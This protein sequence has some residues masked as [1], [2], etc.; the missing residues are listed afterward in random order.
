MKKF[1]SNSGSDST[2]NNNLQAGLS[3]N[4][5]DWILHPYDLNN[6]CIT[7][8]NPINSGQHGRIFPGKVLNSSSTTNALVFKTI[9]PLGSNQEKI[10]YKHSEVDYMALERE[11]RIQKKI[12]SHPN[13]LVFHD[14]YYFWPPNKKNDRMILAFSMDRLNKSLA[15]RINEVMNDQFSTLYKL[16]V[17]LGYPARKQ[18]TAKQT[19]K[20]IAQVLS[21]IGH[22][23]S[24]GLL[25][26]DLNFTN[27]ML[28]DNDN[29]KLIDFSRVNEYDLKN[30]EDEYLHEDVK[31]NIGNILSN[32]FAFLMDYATL[33][34][35]SLTE[36]RIY[37][38]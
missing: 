27:I 20:Y 35:R 33:T 17:Y 7:Q 1:F 14:A 3:F 30:H 19:A 32:S 2:M 38:I 26:V 25:N 8:S 10:R 22:L 29:I 13:I 21:G 11:V 18:I 24:I 31:D 6:I 12:G 28:D 37:L 5:K 34:P 23:I 15:E 36:N 4:L 9:H 16:K